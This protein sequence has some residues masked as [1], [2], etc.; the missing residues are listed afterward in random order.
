[1]SGPTIY[2]R[3]MD[4]ALGRPLHETRDLVQRLIRPPGDEIL[5]ALE[6]QMRQAYVAGVRDGYI[7]AITEQA[8]EPGEDTGAD[9]EKVA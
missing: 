5:S 7:Q 1:M 6:D 8:A 4:N 3:L 9:P 2:G